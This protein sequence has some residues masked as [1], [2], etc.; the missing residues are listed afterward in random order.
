[1]AIVRLSIWLDSQALSPKGTY[2]V[3]LHP[4]VELATHRVSK[5][6]DFMIL[7]LLLTTEKERMFLGFYYIRRNELMNAD[8]RGEG[9]LIN[10]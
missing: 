2:Y 8:D 1:M 5:R 7:L 10:N 6:N 9:T 3:L 4:G